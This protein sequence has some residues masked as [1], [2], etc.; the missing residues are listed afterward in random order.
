MGLWCC[1]LPEIEVMRLRTARRSAKMG[2]ELVRTTQ[3]RSMKEGPSNSQTEARGARSSLALSAFLLALVSIAYGL[4]LALTGYPVQAVPF[5]AGALGWMIALALRTPVILIAVRILKS[6]ERAMPVII[7]ASGP[8]EETVRVI[9]V[10][11]VG[12]DPLT[13]L[14][15]GLG[16]ATIEIAYTYVNIV[17]LARLS[18]SD[19]PKAQ[20]A[21]E[22]L[23]PIALSAES[24]W[25]SAIERAGVTALHIGFTLIVAVVPVAFLITAVMHSAFNL[26]FTR[27]GRNWSIAAIEAAVCAI[28]AVALVVG[29]WLAGVI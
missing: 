9:A 23:P 25:W 19:D 20:Q 14:W 3:Q 13:V 29:L 4:A 18:A 8:A 28:G 10:L 15:L 16:W 21:L 27:L 12:R 17:A 11:L 22:M 5:I 2:R 7:A 26:A 24:P 1:D 6:P